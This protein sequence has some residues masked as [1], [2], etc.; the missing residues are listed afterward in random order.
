MGLRV[1]RNHLPHALAIFNCTLDDIVNVCQE[2]R[3]VA[4]RTKDNH[5]KFASV[6]TYDNDSFTWLISHL[7]I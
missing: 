6:L 1:D 4:E 2:A 3:M 7:S 5:Y